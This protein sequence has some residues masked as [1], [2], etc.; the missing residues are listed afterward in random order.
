M[1]AGKKVMHLEVSAA[2]A[3]AATAA[4]RSRA[5]RDA[6]FRQS[7]ARRRQILIDRGETEKAWEMV[8]QFNLR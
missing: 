6:L 5:E 2:K 7:A 4:M 3:T 1:T 8:R